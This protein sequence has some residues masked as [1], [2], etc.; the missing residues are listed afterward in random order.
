MKKKKNMRLERLSTVDYIAKQKI[1]SYDVAWD[2]VPQLEKK[3]KKVGERSVPSGS[4]A[5]GEGKGWRPPFP[6]PQSTARLA[7][8][9]ADFFFLAFFSTCGAWSQA[10]MMRPERQKQFL[11]SDLN[12]LHLHANV[13]FIVTVNDLLSAQFQINAS[14]LINAPFTRLKF[15]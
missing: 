15:Y 8:S 3:A 14:Y 2:Q 5:Y 4:L 10:T 6:P 7:S 13:R 11:K 9:F 1:R 12:S